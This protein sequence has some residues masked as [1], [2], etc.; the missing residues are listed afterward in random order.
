MLNL[1]DGEFVRLT[2]YL[3]SSFGINLTKKRTLIEGRLN[4]YLSD[5]G[6]LNFT[7]YLDLVLKD[8]NGAE[9]SQL[10]N[11]LT[12]NFSYFL[13]EWDHFEYLRSHVLPGLRQSIP[14]GD[15]RIW[16]AGCST[17]EEPFTLAMLLNDFFAL[18]ASRW[19][20]KVL[21]TDI[22]QKALETA[23]AGSY[24]DEALAKV[25]AEWRKKYFTRQ[26][27]SNWQVKPALRDEVIFRSFN[28]MEE[29]FPFQR[30]FHVIFCR[31]V[32][33]YFDRPTKAALIR[34]FYDHT[35]PGGYLF[36]GQSE[37][38]GREDAPWQYIMPS[39]FRKGV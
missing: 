23:K 9:M 21:A 39:V 26:G 3:Q 28:L 36:V 30:K 4:K 16:S 17:G 14:D 12:T 35:E 10:L 31:N 7:D 8:P 1:T 22:S 19:D 24:E 29:A 5:R 27:E 20:K 37:S 38:I 18:E 13:R 34:R 33:I 2:S 15:L 25:P 11:H 6:F 32:M